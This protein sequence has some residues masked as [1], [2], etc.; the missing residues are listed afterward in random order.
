MVGVIAGTLVGRP[1]GSQFMP[2][3]YVIK[4]KRA[5]SYKKIYR[6]GKDIILE[7]IHISGQL[8][9]KKNLDIHFELI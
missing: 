4:M 8:W 9:H 3:T 5:N 6:V 1:D 7:I 2:N